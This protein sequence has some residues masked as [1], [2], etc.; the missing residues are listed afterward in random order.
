MLTVRKSTQEKIAILTCSGN[1]DLDGVTELKS[2]INEC[3]TAGNMHILINMTEV[4]NVQSSVLQHLLTPIR[5]IVSIRGL[6]V[7]CG[8]SEPIHKVVKTAMFYPIV[9]V[10][11][12]E[13]EALKDLT[14]E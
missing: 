7:L 3:R 8:M 4:T 9:K 6:V 1:I 14:A 5:V 10:Y 2:K 13:E 12:T 11:D